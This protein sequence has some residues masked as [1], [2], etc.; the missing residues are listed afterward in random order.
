MPCYR[1]SRCII[2]QEKGGQ[3]E[4]AWGGQ[5]GPAAPDR[6]DRPEVVNF[7]RRGLIISSFLSNVDT[8]TKLTTLRRLKLTTLRRFFLP[9]PIFRF[10]CNNL[11][12]CF[13]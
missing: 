7:I 12:L 13:R 9:A 1:Q 8:P 10:P 4:L 6:Y 3:F 2:L 11:S 5:F